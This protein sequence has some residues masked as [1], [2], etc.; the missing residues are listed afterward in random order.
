[1]RPIYLRVTN[2]KFMCLKH[3]KAN[4]TETS[5]FR[6]EKGLIAGPWRGTRGTHPPNPTFHKRFQQSI[7]TARMR[8]EV[9]EC[10]ITGE[11]FSDW[12]VLR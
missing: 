12:L 9:E 11:Q 2:H 1:M 8:S 3:T 5:G 6:A 4:Q 7:S 10:V